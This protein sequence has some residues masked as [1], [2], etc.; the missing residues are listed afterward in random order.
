[1]YINGT[2]NVISIKWQGEYLPVGCI[3]SSGFTENTET[4]DSTTRDNNGW[5]S[6]RAVGQGYTLNFSG[7]VINTLHTGGDFTKLSYDR[8][9]YLKRNLT[10]IEWREETKD[11]TFV[12]SGKGIITELGN[13][14]NIDEFISF[15]CT[16][17]GQGKPYSTTG[18]VFQLQDGNGNN[19]QDGQ[20]NNIV[21][22]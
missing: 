2:Y 15:D 6:Y 7:L 4:I 13:T 11:L 14:A 12:S 17:L 3:K 18:Q 22:S 20:G 5:K 21:T 1:M 10:E 16:I 9:Q 19:I 8:L